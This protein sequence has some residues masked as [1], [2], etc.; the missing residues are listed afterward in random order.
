MSQSAVAAPDHKIRQCIQK[1]ALF[2]GRA[3]GWTGLSRARSRA[4]CGGRRRRSAGLSSGVE[5]G[6]RLRSRS[7]LVW[8]YAPEKFSKI[9]FE[10]AYF[11]HFCQLNRSHLQCR[12]GF[13]LGAILLK[14]KPRQIR[15]DC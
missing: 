9:N 6:D 15:Q 5:S 14:Y 1:P 13:Q 8:G 2:L 3:D 12:Q 11:L 7:P 10:I 4:R